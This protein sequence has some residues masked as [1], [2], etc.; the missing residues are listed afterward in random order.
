MKHMAKILTVFCMTLLISLGIFLMPVSAEENG[1]VVYTEGRTEGRFGDS[2]ALKWKYSVENGKKVLTVSS[3]NAEAGDSIENRENKKESPL[4]SICSDVNIIKFRGCKLN[5]NLDYLFADLKSLETV[6]LMTRN[7][8]RYTVQLDTADARSMRHMF[9]GCSKLNNLMVSVYSGNRTYEWNTDR[10]TDMSGMFYGCSSLETIDI[11][12]LNTGRV[13][14]MSDMFYGCTNLKTIY[15]GN[16]GYGIDTSNVTDMSSMFYGCKSLTRVPFVSQSGNARWDIDTS[17]VA[18]MNSMFFGCSSLDTNNDIW[19]ITGL[20]VRSVKDMFAM[21]YGCKALTRLDIGSFDTG[22]VENMGA[23]FAGCSSL[24]HLDVSSFMTSGVKSMYGMFADCISLKELTLVK[25]NSTSFITGNVENMGAMF[26]GCSELRNIDLRNFDTRNVKDMQWMFAGCSSLRALDLSGFDTTN[27]KNLNASD[28]LWDCISLNSITAPNVMAESQVITLPAIFKGGNDEI[29]VSQLTSDYTGDSFSRT[30]LTL[31]A[32]REE[33]YVGTLMQ[34]VLSVD[35]VEL[36]PGAYAQY[37]WKSDN[38]NVLSVS[39]SGEVRA[40]TPGVAT[41]SVAPKGGENI[42]GAKIE[43]KVKPLDEVALHTREINRWTIGQTGWFTVTVNGEEVARESMTWKSSDEDVATCIDGELV[44]ISAGETI[45]TCTRE[46]ATVA[47]CIVK[48]IPVDEVTLNANAINN[49]SIG[50]VG[51]FTAYVNGEAVNR[52]TM[53]WE[54]SNPEVATC[55]NGELVGI[56]A[57]TTTITCT[58]A[59]G[60][61]AECLVTVKDIVTLNAYE[62]KNWTIGRTGTFT[63]YVNN[64]QVDRKTMIWESS[65]PE[66]ATCI[67]GEL[68]GISAGTTTITCTKEYGTVAT[69]KV[70]VKG[71]DVVTLNTE[72]LKNWTIGQTGTFTVYVNGEKVDRTTMTWSSSDPEVATCVQG[73]LVGKSAGT[74]TISCTKAN[75]TVATCKVTV[76]GQ[77]IITLNATEIKN[78]TIGRT[79]TFTPYVNGEKADRATVTWSS[80]N[81]EVATCVQG[82]L[83][84]KSAGT[85]TISCTKANGTVATCEV[86]VKPQD[87]VTLNTNQLN[88]WSIGRVGWFTAYVNGEAVNRTTMTWTSE[89][90]EIVTCIGGELVGV[91]V[92]TTTITCTKA[93]GTVATCEVTVKPQDVVTLNTNQLNNWNVGRVGWFTAY[94]NGEA[95]NRNTMTWTSSNPEVATCTG[96]ELVGV[97]VGTTTITCT[98]TNGTVA[99]CTVTVK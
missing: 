92:G 12:D 8:L 81:P 65:N 49:W 25:N 17:R 59:N 1:G 61:I 41:V 71:Q 73:Y 34:L 32:D 78:W 67:D 42:V 72:E 46:N 38:E 21:F 50:R 3:E 77:D 20:D 40:K 68:V 98:K 96:G 55:I 45:I 75:G 44:G 60:T 99:T 2:N 5:G 36:D 10:V 47:T 70:T 95:V 23:M 51:W 43:I 15:L 26:A 74:T 28:M 6:E 7:N 64:Q 56:S 85:T 29:L 63:V 94:V 97:G 87:V 14:D 27:V 13:A 24:E 90:P 69:C 54:S 89:N 18:D 93:N 79:G 4:K 76:K 33:L 82:Y 22:N 37:A 84:G 39:E 58:K 86:T 88:N 91:G 11:H 57:G 19:T 35:N 83:V 52:E 62:L 9:H 30:Y 31:N 16:W 80:S 53:T 48:V 66:V